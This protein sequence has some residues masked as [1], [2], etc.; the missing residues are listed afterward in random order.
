MVFS[1]IFCFAALADLGRTSNASIELGGACG[2]LILA[3]I[4]WMLTDISG[5]LSKLLARDT[6]A[7][8]ILWMLTDISGKLSKLLARDT[9]A[10]TASAAPTLLQPR[11]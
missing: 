5:K 8:A 10:E 9:N 7:D 6:N 2:L 4:L 1:T 3:A 11:A